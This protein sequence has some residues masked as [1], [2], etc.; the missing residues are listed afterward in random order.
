M[1]IGLRIFYNPAWMGGVNYVLNIAR[2]L[3]TLPDG[4]QP[5]ITFL[6]SAPQAEEIAAEHA[7]LADEIA[8][9][10]NT[11]SLNLDF[12]YPA[13]QLP[14]APFG[15][16]WAG[17]IPD[18][19]C[20]HYPE[21]F[22]PEE[23]ARRFL[24]YRELARGPA[25]C[26]FSSQQAIEDTAK[27]FPEFEK[28]HWKIFHFPAVFDQGFWQEGSGDTVAVRARFNVPDD[29]LIVCNQFWR[30]KNH[31]Q[32]VEALAARPELDVH[33][34]M[35]GAIE[36]TRWP[37]YAASIRELL[38]REDVARRVTITDRISRDE[39]LALL[40]G[41]RG[42][43]QPSLFEGWSTFVEESRALGL[44]GLLSDIPVHRE[45]SPAGSVFFDPNDV[46]SLASAL[47]GFC[48]ELPPR[49]SLAEAGARHADYVTDR[50]RTFMDIARFTA[51][52]FDPARHDAGAVIAKAA[53]ALFDEIGKHPHVTQEAFDR[54]LGNARL[55]LRDNPEDLA[56]IGSMIAESNSAFAAKSDKLL[57]QA[58]LAKAPPEMRQRFLD[59]DPVSDEAARRERIAR[60]QSAIDSPRARAQLASQNFLFR[61]K[62]FIRRKLRS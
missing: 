48:A 62:D 36:D 49:P 9:F 24:Q 25:A 7:G 5:H 2:M 60:M 12:V 39:Q 34:V 56:R 40:K 59:Y 61:L 18:W 28:D 26:V 46:N 8:P 30:H 23:Q 11:A 33:V 21:L 38:A 54:W 44:P 19:Q 55:S 6:T 41:A 53:P 37:D 14:E 1:R 16:P 50:A 47:E 52:R 10:S 57:V 29:Y 22:P 15:A 4:E 45:Q 58:T 42:F 32:I 51:K 31:L 43:V 27:L 35:T 17:W 20:Q 3:R 13:T